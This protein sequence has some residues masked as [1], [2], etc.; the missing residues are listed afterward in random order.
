MGGGGV[1]RKS[2]R[3]ASKHATCVY[4]RTVQQVFKYISY[5][6]NGSKLNVM[7][8]ST[9]PPKITCSVVCILYSLLYYALVRLAN[10]VS[11]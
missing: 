7:S 6:T 1:S 9:S 11:M 3:A 5:L 4:V 8:G 10:T 2:K